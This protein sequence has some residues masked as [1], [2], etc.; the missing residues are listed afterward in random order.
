MRFSSPTHEQLQKHYGRILAGS[1]DLKTNACCCSEESMPHAIRQILKELDEEIIK[2]FYGCGSPIPPALGGCTVLD[3]GCGSGRDV[4]ILSKLV[5][6]NGSVIGGDMT[7]EQLETARK[8]MDAQTARFGY[9][10]ANVDFRQ[11]YIENLKE[12]G[13]EDNSVDVVVSNCVINL[14]PD[15]RSVFSEIFRVL[16]PG[17]ELYFSDIFSRRRVPEQFKD[18]PILHG[19]CLAGAMYTEDFRRL[20]REVGCPDYRVVSGSPVTIDN[21]CIEE[22]I[23]M[24]GFSSMTI[25]AFKLNDLEDICEDYGQVAVYNGKINEHPHFF[26]LDDHHRFLTGKPMLVCGNTASMLQTKRFSRYF[27]ITGDRSVH[28]GAFDCA[29]ASVKADDPSGN[30][31]GGAC[32]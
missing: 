29:P 27:E 26:D 5:G 11:G 20:L 16:K 3:L 15:K 24:V 32:C 30:C 13:M 25:R 21:H 18:D 4:Y 1:K 28:Y 17:G 12:L 7:D 14:S 10:K 23:G 8:H 6:E 31:S 22:K 19:E 2:R 9:R